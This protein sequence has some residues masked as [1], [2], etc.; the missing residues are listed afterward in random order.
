VDRIYHFRMSYG[1]RGIGSSRKRK[2]PV[3]GQNGMDTGDMV[4]AHFM[5]Q[6]MFQALRAAWRR[7][8]LA[9]GGVKVKVARVWALLRR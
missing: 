5:A 6:R 9:D 2:P 3:I 8:G 4:M 1:S 7:G